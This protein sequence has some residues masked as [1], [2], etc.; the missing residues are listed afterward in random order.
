M[1]LRFPHPMILL[2]SCVALA[3]VLTHLVPAGEY[4]RRDDP[5]T[6][7]RVVVAGS[8]HAVAPAPVGPFA[9]VVAVPRGL[10]AAADVI[11]LVLLAGGAWT[12]IDRAGVLRRCVDWLVGRFAQRRWM[13]IAL[14]SLLFAAGG[15]LEN[16]QEEIIPLIPVLLVLAGALGLD[17]VAMVAMSVGAAAVGSAFSPLNP[18]QAGIALKLAQMPL[19]SGAPLRT[20]MLVVALAAWIAWIIRYARRLPPAGHAA[21]AAGPAAAGARFRVMLL[22]VAA[23]FA[24]YVIGVLRYHWG[25]NELSGAFLVAGVLVG[26]VGGLGADGTLE[27]YLEGTRS[28][29]GAAILVGVSRSIYLVLEDG[30][31]ID[32]LLQTLAGPLAH[33]PTALVGIAMIPVQALIHVPV[34][35]VSGQAVLTMPVMIPLADLL[36]LSRHI[37]ILAYQ[38]GAGLM[39]LLTPTNGALMAVLLAAGVRLGPW[40]RFTLPIVGVLAL[41]GVGGILLAG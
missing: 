38:T 31:V 11:V 7:R 34:P 24:A 6:G 16:M 25:F 21:P 4:Q 10:I 27:S 36:G 3:A 35:S 33:A 18:F 23:P 37:P 17:A 41:V 29:L 30:R 32:T 28:V 40:L 26:L 8:Y 19:L 14:L 39:E 22:L 1:R 15:A 13:V 2:L 12:V 20:G 9:A 5:A